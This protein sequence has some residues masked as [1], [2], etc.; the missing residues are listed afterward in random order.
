MEVIHPVFKKKRIDFALR[1]GQRTAYIELKIL[2]KYTNNIPESAR[3]LFDLIRLA[4]ADCNNNTNYFIL[5][6]SKNEYTDSFLQHII[7]NIYFYDWLSIEPG[8]EILFDTNCFAIAYYS[9]FKKQ[10]HISYPDFRIYTQLIAKE[11]SERC[12]TLIWRVKKM[13]SIKL[14]SKE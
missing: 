8:E 5:Y 12:I 6:G 3:I 10:F 13:A 11:E 7:C 14:L 9:L 1:V 2:H 4:E